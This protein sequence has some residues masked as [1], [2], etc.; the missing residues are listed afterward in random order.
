[1]NT[2][3]NAQKLIFLVLL[4]LMGFSYTVKSQSNLDEI[5]SEVTKNNKAIIAN[6]QYWKA[7]R[8]GF[9][10]G[11]TPYNPSV[12]Y[13]YLNGSP[14]G[15]GTQKDFSVIQAF[16]FPTAYFNKNELSEEQITQTN[17]QS[18]AFRQD[19]LLKAKLY[20]LELVYLNK[21]NQVLSGRLLSVEGLYNSYQRRLEEGEANILDVTKAKIQFVNL[22]NELRRIKMRLNKLR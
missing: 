5:L 13:E 1:M 20:F 9:K 7:R 3:F 19:I 18:A 22:Q 17:Y 4:W 8:L 15:A 12:E 10:T 11:L 16:D 6:Q 2:I 21:Q 14:A